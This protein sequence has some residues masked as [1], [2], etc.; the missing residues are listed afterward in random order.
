MS[1]V[2]QEKLAVNPQIRSQLEADGVLLATIDMPGRSMNVFSVELMDALDALMDRVDS[3]PAVRCVVLTSGKPA[4]LAGADLDMVRGYTVSARSLGADALF[5]LCGR[6]GRQFVRLEASA[7]PWVAAVNGIAMGGGLELAMACRARL[8]TD[9]PRTQLSLPEVRWGLL[10]GAGGTQRLPRL[11]GFEAGLSL[12]LTGRS[13]DPKEAVAR[14][15]FQAAVPAERL[16]DDARALARSLQGQHFNAA[17]KFGHLVQADVPLYSPEAVRALARQHGVSAADF[18][19][20]PAFETIINCVLLGANQPLAE[21]TA[22]E[23]RQFLRLMIDPVA[24]QMVRTLF[25]NRQRADRELA[26]PAGLRIQGI[27]VGP[28]S[29]PLARWHDALVKSRVALHHD[30]SLPPDSLVLSD[31][32]GHVHPVRIGTL[33]SEPGNGNGSAAEAVLSASGPYGCVLEIVKASASAA[34]ALASLAPRLGAALPYRSADGASVLRRLAG[35]ARESLDAQGLVA[36]GLLAGGA[37]TKAETLDV[38][39][40]AAGLTPAW[41]GGPLAHFWTHRDRLQAQLDPQT[42]AAWPRLEPVLREACA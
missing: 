37:A 12:L 20:Y 14:G 41:T 15:V 28:L 8:V 39:A 24:G 17:D 11:V 7:K 34:Q 26:A 29:P 5:A 42:L 31:T 21:A 4:F 13:M 27:A 40:C 30:A 2:M 36:V 19:D 9:D 38:A 16:M 22:T 18:R 35:A 23:M 33:D 32:Q 25:L 10:P 1:A 6:L 3:D